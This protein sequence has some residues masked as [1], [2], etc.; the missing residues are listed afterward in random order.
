MEFLKNKIKENLRQNFH[1]PKLFLC[2]IL[3]TFCNLMDLYDTVYSFSTSQG[4]ND[5]YRVGIC[6]LVLTLSSN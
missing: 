3:D 1:N 2:Y 4:P 6:F 5:D